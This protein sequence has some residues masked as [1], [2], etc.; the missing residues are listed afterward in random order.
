M[1]THVIDDA[2]IEQLGASVKGEVLTPGSAGY[3]DACTIFNAMIE[4]RPA[5]IV[6]AKDPADVIAAVELA[7]AS[8]AELSVRSGGHGVTGAALTDGGITIDMSAM[9]RIRV[10]PAARIV[11]AQA[12]V[13]WGELD[14]AA[15]EHG[16]AVTGGRVPSTGIAGL[17]LGSGSGWLERKHGYTCDNLLEADVVTADGR[18]LRVNETENAD[19]FW[20]L[21]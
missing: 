12:G 6:R 11:R 4:K 15:Q 8:A 1:A 19:L 7:R 2:A 18:F 10:D 16:L 20:A 21:K 3:G 9:K 13:T 17:T 5:A 14:A